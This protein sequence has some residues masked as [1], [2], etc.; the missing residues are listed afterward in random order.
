MLSWRTKSKGGTNVEDLIAR[1]KYGQ[2]IDAM[3][4]EFQK[5]S[6]D[7]AM[8]HRIAEVL[9][10]A[11]RGDEAVPILLGLADEHFR[12]GFLDRAREALAWIEKVEKGRKDV[13]QR[14]VKIELQEEALAEEKAAAE[15][16]RAGKNRKKSAPPVAPPPP[17]EIELPA[18]VEEPVDRAPAIAVQLGTEG[19]IGDL[20]EIEV[21]S[22][23]EEPP[24]VLQLELAPEETEEVEPLEVELEAEPET[25]E[26]EAMEAMPIEP[27]PAGEQPMAEAEP[28]D[29]AEAAMEG[30]EQLA[31]FPEARPRTPRARGRTIRPRA[32]IEA[33]ATKPITRQ[34]AIAAVVAA[35]PAKAQ[36]GATVSLDP[37]SIS[38]IAAFAIG[39]VVAEAS[40]GRQDLSVT[41]EKPASAGRQ[42][43]QEGALIVDLV[44]DLVR[45]AETEPAAK[46]RP[47]LAGLLFEGIDAVQILPLLSGLHHRACVAGDVV[48][49][50]GE[51]G[52]SIFI[53]ASGSVK[54]FVRSPHGRNFE[55][56]EIG[57]MGFFGEVA[58][59]SGRRRE[60]SIVAACPTTLLEIDKDAL[61]TLARSR[62]AARQLLEEA[63]VERAMSPAA[64]AV[65]AIPED[66]A[67]ERA[68]AA[69]AQHF[70]ESRWSVR[71]RLRLADVLLKAANEK[72]ALAV[73]TGV[74]EDLASAGRAEKAIAVLKK[75]Q[76]ISK[77]GVAEL[78]LA[79]LG[80]KS[81]RRGKGSAGAP[82]LHPPRPEEAFRGWLQNVLADLKTAADEQPEGQ[83]EALPLVQIDLAPLPRRSTAR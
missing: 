19:S 2:A 62:P 7:A 26:V 35:A 27:D 53:V 57:A 41:P 44:Q 68:A 64:A 8:R 71:M 15:A 60:A 39:E 16:E 66:V 9:I 40:A 32:P 52:D 18:E 21:P 20:E 76:Q 46:G 69:L 4:E 1:K 12:F 82:G 28:I 13:A 80:K 3:R 23:E 42:D 73:L 22:P 61:D 81:A 17:I 29:L 45:R 83:G 77:R 75:I 47:I 11:D 43:P 74:A 6:P 56:D 5:K 55:V 25:I 59:L 51:S 36:G 33:S 30:A 79:P 49:T 50:E 54:V 31:I 24:D 65:R 14:R 38:N 10:L 78:R 34:A 48:L 72:D 58:A 67:G 70:G 63:C 37:D